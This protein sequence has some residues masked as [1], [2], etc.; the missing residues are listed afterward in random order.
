M[1]TLSRFGYLSRSDLVE[2]APKDF[3]T[4]YVGQSGGRTSAIM[5]E[6]RGR[7]LFIDEA[8]GFDPAQGGNQ[9]R[10]EAVDTMVALMTN[11]EYNGKM[12]I[13]LAG[14]EEN[15][16][17]MLDSPLL[18]PGLR[19]RF[20]TKVQ[21]KPFTAK[22]S[23][24]LLSKLLQ[25]KDLKMEPGLDKNLLSFL[26]ELIESMGHSWASAG[27]V[28][29]LSEAIEKAVAKRD[30]DEG[31]DLINQAVLED[32]RARL[33]N[34]RSSGSSKKPSIRSPAPAMME[35]DRPITA[36]PP[37][38]TTKTTTKKPEVKAPV[39]EEQHS[40]DEGEGSRE[41]AATDEER[42]KAAENK[43]RYKGYLAELQ[44]ERDRIEEERKRLEELERKIQEAKEAAEKERLRKLKEAAEVRFARFVS[45]FTSFRSFV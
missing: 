28:V 32:A 8:Y 37:Q 10:K 2:K 16:E 26:T 44:K 5:D 39:E 4:G 14:Y 3:E 36:T 22:D 23:L 15:I 17:D 42:K 30:R 1:V 38:I 45:D 27:S 18:N 41:D 43:K 24:G 13:V 34:N 31:C 25:K 33:L 40:H 9:F 29:A 21:F 12:V 20:S 7:V 19:R 35:S 6:A 11:P